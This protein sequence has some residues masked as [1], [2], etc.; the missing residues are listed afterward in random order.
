MGY[1]CPSSDIAH[2]DRIIARMVFKAGTPQIVN[3]IKE[4]QKIKE[5]ECG[6]NST[7]GIPL[8]TS[9]EVYGVLTLSSK[10]ENHFKARDEK[11]LL[12]LAAQAAIAIENYYLEKINWENKRQLALKTVIN[13]ESEKEYKEFISSSK[14]TALRDKIPPDPLPYLIHGE[15]GVGKN[16]LARDVHRKSP[17]GNSPFIPV[18]CAT[19]S[20]SHLSLKL[21][22]GSNTSYKQ[23]KSEVDFS[24]LELAEGGTLFLHNI[25]RLPKEL[26]ERLADII[27]PKSINDIELPKNVRIVASTS[28]PLDKKVEKGEFDLSLFKALTQNILYIPPLRERKKDILKLT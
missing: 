6:I 19:L 9:E 11:L 4:K 2:P 23:K 13:E 7:I 10:K 15:Y 5:C 16:L 27:I 21:M 18:D 24:Y 26:G 8:K 12:S 25:D 1:L 14:S 22:F 28:V 3:D 20:S 17:R